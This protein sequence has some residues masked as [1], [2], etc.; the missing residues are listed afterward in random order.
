MGVLW[1]D[2][3][4]DKNDIVFVISTSGRNPVPIDVAH[5]AKE[6]GAFVIGMT[7]VEYSKSQ[8]S[9]HKSGQYLF[10]TVDHV[11][12]THVVIGDAILKHAKVKVPF[13][14]ISTVVGAA[15]LNGV[16]AESIR[17]MADSDFEPPIFLSG[18]LEGADEHNKRLVEKYEKRIPLLTL[19]MK[20][21]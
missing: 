20:N 14:P 4:S 15:I 1:I 9:R 16:F 5:Y 18:N 10:S 2:F 8:A 19:N 13:A 11:I 3:K 17:I 12:D 6:Q 21:V 7:S